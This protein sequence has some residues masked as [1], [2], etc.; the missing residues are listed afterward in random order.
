MM[1][2]EQQAKAVALSHCTFQVGSPDKRFVRN[3]QGYEGE[4]TEKQAAYLD[5]LCYR[6]RKQLASIIDNPSQYE[7]WWKAGQAAVEAK[8]AQP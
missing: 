2:A 6:Y 1:S 3:L 7:R 4:L 8:K 5:R